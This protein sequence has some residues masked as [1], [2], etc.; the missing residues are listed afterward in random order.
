L[1]NNAILSGQSNNLSRAHEQS[2]FTAEQ[3]S[4]GDD[5]ICPTTVV[6]RIQGTPGS[7]GY[8][9][10][11]PL[12]DP[13]QISIVSLPANLSIQGET[14]DVGSGLV[15]VQVMHEGSLQKYQP[16]LFS[17][18]NGSSRWSASIDINKVGINKL[19]IRAADN[20]GNVAYNTIFL[21]VTRESKF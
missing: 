21:N 19:V 10:Y 17:M 1:K 14:Y 7:T 20:A 2:N 15:S 9:F 11:K 8:F 6:T 16:V 4:R 12:A 13:L 3:K 18:S 5:T